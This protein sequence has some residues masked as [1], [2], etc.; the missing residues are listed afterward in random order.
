VNRDKPPVPALIRYHSLI[1]ATADVPFEFR[2]L[3]M[4]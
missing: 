3:P 1:R 2:N 4:P